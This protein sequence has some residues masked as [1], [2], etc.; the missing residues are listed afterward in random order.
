MGQAMSP[1]AANGSGAPRGSLRGDARPAIE[2]DR[3]VH[4]PGH[5]SRRLPRPG[6]PGALLPGLLPDLL[7]FFFAWLLAF[8]VKPPADWLQRHLRHLPR[9]VAVLLVIIPIIV[10]GPAILARLVAT[11]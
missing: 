9:P 8:L 3:R 7:I 1:D 6:V 2:L 4:R 5:D 10:V 11:T